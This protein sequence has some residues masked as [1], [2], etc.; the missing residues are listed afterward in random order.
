[1][2]FVDSSFFKDPSKRLPTPAEV[3]AQ[4]TDLYVNPQPQPVIFEDSKVLVK[5]GPC[6]MT[7]EA[8]CLWMIKR[9]FGDEVPVPE[10][11]GWRVDEDYVFIYMELIQGQTLLDRWD[12]LDALNKRSLCDQLCQIINSLRRLEQDPSNQYIGSLSHERQVLDYVFQA[13]LK[14]GPFSN[15]Q[16]FN[17]WFSSLPQYHFPLK[18]EDPYRALLPDNGDIKFTHADLH[19]ANI[20]VSSSKPARILAIVDWGQSGWYPDYWEY[21][22]AGYTCWSESEWRREWIDHC[23]RPRTLEFDIFSEYIMAMGAV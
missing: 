10:I 23:L 4:S 15:I 6:V 3:R 1:M 16:D 17:D 12:E 2:D 8:Q 11:F 7:A 5:F 22:K 9:A 13:Y 19:R 21:C 14:A 20:M 18:Y